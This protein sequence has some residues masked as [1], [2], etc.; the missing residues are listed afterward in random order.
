MTD[1]KFDKLMKN[2]EDFLHN[3]VPRA[4]RFSHRITY[5]PAALTTSWYLE[6]SEV[7]ELMGPNVGAGELR[8]PVEKFVMDC[9]STIK[10]IM[11]ALKEMANDYDTLEQRFN[12]Y[13]EM[14][15]SEK[16]KK[17][18]DHVNGKGVQ[19]IDILVGHDKAHIKVENQKIPEVPVT[20]LEEE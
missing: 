8:N 9:E 13:K 2:A 4:Y 14:Q 11:G 5:N 16:A 12:E 1:K 18:F 7:K 3:N 15:P 17:L 20:T 10:A 19:Q 6:E